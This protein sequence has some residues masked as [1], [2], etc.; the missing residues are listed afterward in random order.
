MNLEPRPGRASW[1]LVKLELTVDRVTRGKVRDINNH[2]GY[3]Q[4]SHEDSGATLG[5]WAPLNE[6][7]HVGAVLEVTVTETG[8]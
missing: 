5:Y 1:P 2:K 3:V 4:A 8:P 7:P 6:A